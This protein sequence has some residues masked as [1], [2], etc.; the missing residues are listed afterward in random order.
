MSTTA[1]KIPG[2]VAGTFTIDPVTLALDVNGF[3]G[4][5]YGGTRAGFSATTEL[6]RGD[7]AI[8]TNIPMDGG[9]WS[10]AT[11]SRPSSRLK[12]S[13]THPAGQPPG[14]TADLQE[15]DACRFPDRTRTDSLRAA[16]APGPGRTDRSGGNPRR[17]SSR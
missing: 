2:Y 4:D 8:S 1:V 9:G 7:F 5:P 12:P 13:A 16:R 15:E 11:V 14:R 3:T 10:S 6:D 17:G